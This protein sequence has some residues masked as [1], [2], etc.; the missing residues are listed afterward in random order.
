MPTA[1]N[2][3]LEAMLK[4]Y[5]KIAFRYLRK[6][7][8]F[9]I[10]NIVGLTLGF[11][12]AILLT[13]YIA[14]ELSFD[15]FHTDSDR[16]YRV[17]QQITEADGQSRTVAT[18]APL[19]ATEAK[20]QFPEVEDFVRLIEIGRL[21]VGNDPL[22]RD[23]ERIWIADSNFFQFFDYEFLYGNADDALTQPD[24]L[25]ITESTA[26]KYFGRADVV[27]ERLYTN[28]YQA[29]VSAVIK[30]FPPNSHLDINTIHAVPTW[31]R[32]ISQ[33]ND[34]VSS[35][36]TSNSFVTYYKVN[37][38][39]DK[40][41]FEQKLTKLVTENYADDIGYESTFTLQPL[42]EIHLYSGDIQG[43]MNVSAGNPLYIYMFSIVGILLLVIA[44]FNYMN[45][46][47]AAASRRTREVGMRKTLG[48]H[49]WQLVSQFVGEALLLSLC[50][51]LIAVFAIEL[52]LPWINAFLGQSLAL[53]FEDLGLFSL[54]GVLVLVAGSAS[55]L[56]PAFF[57][58]GVEPARALKHEIKVGGGTFSLRKVLVVAQ[59]V[60]SIVM[61]TTT[62][63][64]YN[65][66]Q[67]LQ[68]KEVGFDL[69]NLLVVD[70]KSGPLRAQFESI[71]QEFEQLERIKSVTVSSRVPGEWKN[72]PI[73]N[74]EHQ[75]SEASTQAIFIGADED[76]LNTYE[77]ELVEGRFLRND[78]ADSNSV[79]LSE[80]A[81]KQLGL[82]DP[83]GQELDIPSTVWNGDLNEQD[84][85]YSPKVIGVVKDFHFESFRKEMR[86]MVM[87][88]YR[89]PIHNIDYYTLR[90]AKADWQQL[91]PVLQ[92]IN[93]RF[94]PENPME[95]TFLDNRFAQFYEAD[96]L[97]GQLFM[98]FSL[99][100][101]LIAC[102]GL[103]ALASFAIEHRIKEIG[104]RKVLGATVGD[105][106]WLL[107]KDFA[108]LVGL[109]FLL[110]IP[111]G[112]FAA[113]SWLQEFAYRIAIPW[114][115]FFAA[116]LSAML[117]ALITISYQTLRAALMNPVESLRSE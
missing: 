64:I 23:Y 105:L 98:I 77:I 62:I 46:S 22:N 82:E 33:W 15:A 18:V 30:D 3:K 79:L 112:W 56:Y 66:L 65:Q 59:F 47:T 16:I 41:A 93:N 90:A 110:A 25:V 71:K 60:I 29:T 53:P 116:G 34:W 87:A 31:E 109:A 36:W 54:M 13:L 26:R 69:D 27:G 57:L 48:A 40:V 44:C 1:D 14:E 94:D 89:N 68:Q 49:K 7:K 92:E 39:F 72:F 51:L 52:S 63:I 96:Q 21:T 100:I 32:E 101:V 37:H 6:N 115:G 70:I 88:S 58:S 75:G 83:I 5:L 103:F 24:N 97:R 10:V 78:V 20:A 74:V 12:C 11:Y 76:F 9:S 50:S 108:K 61:I 43:G 55:A 107:S 67:Y 8:V 28:V 91:L 35:N 4:S 117:I 2:R 99:V 45:L 73:A 17:I 84:Y 114:W 86:P 85:P 80:L 111:F 104:I 19:I 106:N 38:G 102:L 81:V 95:Y 113:Q 42:T